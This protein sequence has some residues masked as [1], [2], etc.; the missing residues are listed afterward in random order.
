MSFRTLHEITTPPNCP[1]PI[2]EFQ[3]AG[4][5][6]AIMNLVHKN[7]F[8]K[9][10]PIQAQGWPIALSGVDL[11]GIARTGSGKTLAFALPAIIHIAAQPA[12]S[13]GE[14]PIALVL[15]P[16]RELAQQVMKVCEEFGRLA[17][18]KTACLYGGAPKSQQIRDLQ[19]GA[20]LV[21][22]TPGRLIDLLDMGKT[23]LKRCTYLVMDEA[24]RMLDMGFE[25]QIRTIIS[26]VRPDRQTLL[27][28]ATWPREV[29]S[30]ARDFQRDPCQIYVGSQ[31]LSANHNI[32]QIVDVIQE[33]EK[34]DRLQQ[35][36]N[37]MF[38]HGACK[39]LIFTATKKMAND[40]SHQLRRQGWPTA[41]IHG[42]KKQEEREQALG[43]F[44]SG[45]CSILIATD[46]ASRGID[47]DDI[48]FVINYDYPNSAE[49]YVH[50]IG[51]TAR[52]NNDGTSYTFMTAK[53][54]KNVRGLIAVLEEAKQKVP[55]ELRQLQ[56]GSGGR[57]EKRRF[58]GGGGG[59]DFN[60]R[61][62]GGS[63][64]GGGSSR[65][66]GRGGSSY[67]GAPKTNGYS[68]GGRGG[69]SSYSSGG[70]TYQSNGGGG[71]GGYGQSNGGG[72]GGYGGHS[73]G[74]Y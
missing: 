36:L 63:S 17:N 18:L 28:S 49:D 56:F 46:V 31:T 52:A 1:N 11:V 69:G 64:F 29:Q 67:G 19:Q 68:G 2:C 71:G 26:Q 10:T 13:P 14:G 60:K 24:D 6:Q 8:S 48:K 43:Q 47:I 37:E 41:A 7:G 35:L 53:D 34:Y 65:G 15:C 62:R 42:D 27:W 9:P 12:L 59:G 57:G 30:L 20:D 72:G 23:N 25:P 51:R 5:N 70:T 32:L 40:I 54:G 16:T 45:Q 22:A 55:E 38:A 58:N 21:V 44:R 33:Y 61:A 3:E 50:R 73:N 39:T 66:G 4:F 74:G